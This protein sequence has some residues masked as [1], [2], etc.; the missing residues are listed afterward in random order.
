MMKENEVVLSFEDCKALFPVL[1]VR[2]TRL[3]EEARGV[4]LRIERLLYTALSVGE[5]EELSGGGQDD[6]GDFFYG[7]PV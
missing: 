1:K 2:E 7:G 5:V 6:G 4:L 3:P